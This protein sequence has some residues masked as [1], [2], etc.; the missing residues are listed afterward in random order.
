MAIG[1]AVVIPDIGL[2]VVIKHFEKERDLIKNAEFIIIDKQEMMLH[3]Y[4]YLGNLTME[5]PIACGK[6]VGNKQRQGDMRTPEGVFRI[7]EIEDASGW[8]HD[9]NDGE[10]EIDSAYGPWF[11][12]LDTPGH[13]G[14]GI[15]GTH[16]PETIGTR[17]TEGCIRMNNE[18][19][20]RLKERVYVGM[21]VVIVPSAEDV[22]TNVSKQLD[23]PK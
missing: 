14:I 15:H 19:L 23:S 11:I 2:F 6:N 17:A 12:R 21:T 3:M 4:D 13:S 8:S 18:D 9:F 20:I 5:Y 7:S 1:A 10:G 16:I 22:K